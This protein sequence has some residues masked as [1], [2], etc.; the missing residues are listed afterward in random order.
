MTRILFVCHG[1]RDEADA[2]ER[3]IGQ[4]RALCGGVC[5]IFC[6]LLR[7]DY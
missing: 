1:R 5:P 6:V 3:I 2:R 7:V 4:Y